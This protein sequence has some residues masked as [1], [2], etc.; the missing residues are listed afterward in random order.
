MRTD[1]FLGRGW[2]FPPKINHAGQVTLAANE[3]KIQ[4]SIQVIIRTVPGERVMRPTF[5]C[6]IHELIFAPANDQTAV[7]A[8]RYVREA[9]EQWEPRIRLRTVAVSPHFGTRTVGRLDINIQYE[10]KGM[11]DV[12]SLVFPYYLLP[13]D[14]Q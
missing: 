13:A 11:H 1:D 7:T 14:E 8:E 10:I 2:S 6:R 9:L 5:G 4:Q 12:R 3:A